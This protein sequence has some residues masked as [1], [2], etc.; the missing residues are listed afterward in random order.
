MYGSYFQPSL[1]S[2]TL[3]DHALTHENAFETFKRDKTILTLVC[4]THTHRTER[5]VRQHHVHRHRARIEFYFTLE[6]NNTQLRPKCQ[7]CR[8]P[9][10]EQS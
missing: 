5:H 6:T 2:V 9:S 1:A 10:Y 8:V 3:Y 4:D 7:L